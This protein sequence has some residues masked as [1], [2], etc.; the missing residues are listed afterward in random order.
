VARGMGGRSFKD[1]GY[2]SRTLKGW[3]G[4]VG[5]NQR[6]VKNNVR[7]TLKIE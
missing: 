4:G 6:C 1:D 3:E 7:G 5:K 2:T